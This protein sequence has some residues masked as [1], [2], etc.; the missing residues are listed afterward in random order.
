MKKLLLIFAA[1][2]LFAAC[3]N[4]KTFKVSGIIT[5]LGSSDEPIMLYLKTRN[6]A[7]ELINVDSTFLTADGSFVLKGKS[8]ETDLFFLTDKDNV[9]VVRIFVEPGKNV[10]VRGSMID[11][12][13]ILIEGSETQKLYESY[14][15]LIKPMKEEQQQIEQEYHIRYEDYSIPDEDRKTMLNELVTAFEKLEKDIEDCT[16][17]FAET[18]SNSIV[19]A[20]LVYMNT[21]TSGKSAD[22]E[23]QL[24]LLD[25]EMNNKFV[26]LVKSLL[27]R[28]KSTEVGAVLPTIELPDADG[29]LINT[30]SLRGK[31]LLVDFWASW[32]RPCVREIPN[33][34]KAYQE[35]HDKGFEI[36]SI[37]LDDNK[38][39][40]LNCIAFNELN[41][42]HVSDLQSFNS[43]VA[44]KI[45]IN[46]IPH[47]FLLDSNGVILAVDLRGD[48]LIDK[49][50]EIM[51]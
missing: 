40:W 20:Y 32:C 1:I 34:K 23:A 10:T 14:L 3:T 51:Q 2:C 13:D 42:L 15:A 37:S 21:R 19:A 28:V 25:K 39:A 24:Q 11:Y 36:I 45:A 17:N 9:F 4:E 48:E 26:K 22:I 49:L 29:K 33:L 7:E 31:Y 27:E 47:T 41:W 35:Y 46:Y 30:E 43:P 38:E 16:L 50:A 12:P 8:S 44:K 6:A 5:D 18:N